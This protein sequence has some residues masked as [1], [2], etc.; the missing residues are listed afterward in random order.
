MEDLHEWG[1]VGRY[2][3]DK[4]DEITRADN[5]NGTAEQIR[6]E[7]RS[8]QR[9]E[10]TIGTA[11]NRPFLRIGYTLINRPMN[12]IHEVI[13][14]FPAPL[15]VASIQKF[16]AVT[17]KATLINLQAGIATVGK[18]LC[19]GIVPPGASCPRAAVNIEHHG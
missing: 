14:H 18:P 17:A 15:L 2:G 9:C 7:C 10:T 13:V 16:F 5:I 3:P 11:V 12:A 8:N 4:G 19:L 6:R 1:P